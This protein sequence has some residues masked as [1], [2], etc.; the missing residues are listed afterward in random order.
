MV[1][2]TVLDA[3]VVPWR[4]IREL[5]LEDE[6]DV[7]VWA[8]RKRSRRHARAHTEEEHLALCLLMLA[9]G[10][11]DGDRH[12][13]HRCNVCGKVFSSHQALGGHKS[14]HRSRP[15][16]TAIQAAATPQVPASSSGSPATS[17]STSGTGKVHECSVC[18]KTFPTGQAL[19]GHK[20]C[21][22]EGAVG[23][24]TATA[25]RGF[26]LNIPALPDIAERCFSPAAAEEEDEVLSPLAFKKPRLSLIPA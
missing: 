4:P 18:K 17:S 1:V 16:V 9:R 2:D 14:S 25:G 8:K 21:H 3:A 11:R 22:Y 20:R 24:T 10:H 19:G 5:E 13:Q 6:Q 7:Q 23:S 26:D 15:P 12:H